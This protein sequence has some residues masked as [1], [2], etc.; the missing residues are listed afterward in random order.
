MGLSSRVRWALLIAVGFVLTA[1]GSEVRSLSNSGSSP[2]SSPASTQKASLIVVSDKPAGPDES[3][4]SIN[5][6]LVRPDGSQAQQLTVKQGAAVL[7]ARGER[8]F[9]KEG[10]AL[11][12]LHKDGTVETLGDLGASNILAFV[13][14]PDGNRWMWGTEESTSQVHIA[15]TGMN[16]RVVAESNDPRTSVE[17]FSWTP[18]AP[19]VAHATTGLGDRVFTPAAGPV[20]KLDPATFTLQPIA[21]TDQCAFSDMARDGTVACV[22]RLT[23]PN[24]PPRLMLMSPDG[25]TQTIKLNPSNFPEEGDAYFSQ[26]GRLVTIAGSTGYGNHSGPDHNVTDLVTA[27]DGSIRRLADGLRPSSDLNWQTWLDDGSLVLWRPEGAAGGPAGVFVVSPA[28][29]AKQISK[30]GFAVGL[31]TG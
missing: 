5:L 20:E 17:P 22:R 3:S 13:A 27:K 9:I 30:G 10:S 24:P 8:I 18:V 21:H 4:S 1:C 14:S 23:D 6:R 31:I 29:S 25:K 2:G 19:F 16:P 12:A 7:A 11:K 26:D 28:G 15:G